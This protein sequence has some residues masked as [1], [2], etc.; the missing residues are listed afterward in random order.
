M[1]GD[2]SPGAAPVVDE[3]GSGTPMDSPVASPSQSPS[4]LPGAASPAV[5]GAGEGVEDAAVAAV[6]G[7]GVGVGVGVG[8]GMVLVDEEQS[9]SVARNGGAVAMSNNERRA[10]EAVDANPY[11][12]DAWNA[13]CNEAQAKAIGDAASIYEQLLSTFP[14][15][16]KFWR[17]YV[18]AELAANDDDAV[19]QIFS[20]C[21]LQ[22][23]HVDLWRAYLRYMRKVNDNRGP[24]GRE[25]MKKAFEFMLGHI[26]FDINAGPVWLEYISFLKAAPAVTP[27][28]ESFRMTAVRKAYQKAILAPVH[29]VE[30]IWKE[31]ESF[32]N[33]V[34]RALAKGLLAEYQPKHF[35]AR[36]VYRE[37]K[38]Y[39]DRIDTNMLAVP[40]TGSYKEEQQCIAWKQLLTFEKGNPQRLDPVGLTKH[41]AFTYEQCLMY[42]YHYPD[43][44]YDYA[45]WHAQNGSLDSAAVIYQRALTALPDTAVLHYAYAEFEEARGGI[46][47]A[48]AVYETLIKN[49]TTANALAYIQLM[50]FVRRTEGIEAARKIFMEARKSPAC[51]YHVYVASATMELCVD[52]DPKVARN[53]FELGL[54]KYIHEPPYVLEYADFL[55]RM[56]DERNVRVLFERALSVLPAEESAE[57]WNRFLAF[58]QTYGDLASTLKVE[59]R[60]KEA[61]S[62][63]GDDGALA[64]EPSL[65][66]L[67]SRYRFLDLWPCSSSDLDHM[68]RQ[69][70]A[71][72][73]LSSK[74]E[75]ASGHGAAT[76]G[77]RDSGPPAERNSSAGAGAGNSGSNINIVRPDISAMVIY[78]PRQGFGVIT[79]GQAVGSM[80]PV[81]R[82]GAGMQF[83]PPL[84][85]LH[86]AAPQLIQGAVPMMASGGIPMQPMHP[87]PPAGPRPPPL[88]PGRP[89]GE[90]G[91][92]MKS[93]EDALKLLPPS[94]GSFLTRLPRAVSGPY[95]D[96]DTVMAYLLQT[97][98][99][100]M[101]QEEGIVVQSGAR[102]ASPAVGGDR[103]GASQSQERN[104]SNNRP[105]Y[106]NQSASEGRN[107]AGSNSRQSRLPPK[108][109]DPERGEDDEDTPGPQNRP[110]PRDVFR[111]RQLQRA[112]GGGSSMQS[113]STSGNSGA[114][115]GDISGSSE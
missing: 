100:A 32:E 33:S 12:V 37:R 78:D 26:G 83:G 44:W 85:G 45:T 63:S 107:A 23:L 115:S 93:V 99:Q 81:A 2:D 47:E 51:T 86:P 69:Q 103:H 64:A 15:S 36:A 10:R 90:G 102:P 70:M 92:I 104:N 28:E 112:R 35:S 80:Q 111:L 25:E 4:P 73:K 89:P 50:R 68:S 46:K 6:V 1:K 79:Q 106:S 48:K 52:K 67:I 88:P 82:M 109:K 113:G 105:N 58:E 94:L 16:A 14:T 29:L 42:L 40:P 74:L 110:P 38:K 114:F 55:C 66:R 91:G 34:S 59:Q 84:L 17:L 18:E 19:K 54:K 39:C 75:K 41:V 7:G 20:R 60:R 31:Y 21:L 8:V 97:D 62:Q 13:L 53:I 108:R 27:Q 76:Q 43:I 11:D 3:D 87:P 22:C 9:P 49:D 96:P 65:Q 56:N 61:L 30:Q 24:E 72:P 57:V 101:M 77:N 71:V 98:L 5:S 95:P